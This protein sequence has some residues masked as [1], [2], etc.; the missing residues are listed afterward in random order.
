MTPSERAL[1]ERAH[2]QILAL[3]YRLGELLPVEQRARRTIRQRV[4]DELLGCPKGAR[5][6]ELA[7]ALDD[8]PS[9][10]LEQAVHYLVRARVLVVDR[11]GRKNVYRLAP[12]SK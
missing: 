4:I 1:L 11:S 6:A 5:F 3:L 9:K 8:V 10:S 2:A 7:D 12:V